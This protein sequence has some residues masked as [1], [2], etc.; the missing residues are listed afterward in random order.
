VNDDLVLRANAVKLAVE[1]GK[2]SFT[3]TKTEYELNQKILNEA[4]A[5][6]K[7]KYGLN[8]YEELQSAV[9]A[10]GEKIATD[11]DKIE[12]L[13]T[14]ANIPLPAETPHEV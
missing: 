10:L 7:A 13:L 9:K 4:L 5:E 12:T 3:A 2:E 1:T 14:A 11:L 6:V 8:S